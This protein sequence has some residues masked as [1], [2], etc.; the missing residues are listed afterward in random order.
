MTSTRRTGTLRVRAETTKTRAGRVVPYSAP[1]GEL[2]GAYLAHRR[3][4]ARARGALL[5]SESR[6]NRGEPI[7]PWT[8]SKVA[9]GRGCRGSAATRCAISV[10]DRSGP[11]GLELHAISTFP[12]HRSTQTTLRYIHLSRRDLAAR[13]GSGMAQI[14]AERVAQIGEAL[15]P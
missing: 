12:G 6:R 15:S 1:A 9:R 7:T 4:I 5:V 2:L 13:L 10:P 8:W 3:T 11:F 14:H